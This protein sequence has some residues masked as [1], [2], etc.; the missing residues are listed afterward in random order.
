[1]KYLSVC[2][3]I[4]AA[5]VAWHRLGY[6]PVGFSEIEPFPS[7]VLAHHYPHVPNFGDM[8]KFQEWTLDAGSIDLLVGGT[9]CQSFSVA[10]LRQG[11]KDPR[12]NLMLTYLAIAARLRPQWVVWENVPGV[13]SSNRGRDFGSFL[14]G[15]GQLGYGFAYRVLDAQW[16]RTHGHPCAV[17]QRRRR[18]FVVGCLGNATAAAKVLFERESVQR[19]SAKSG[20]ARKEVAANVEDGTRT[21]RYWGSEPNCADTVTSKWSKGSGGPA[22]SECGLFLTQPIANTLGSRGVRSHTELDGHGAYIPVPIQDG[23]EINKQQNGIGVGQPGDPAYTLDTTGS[24]SVYTK[25]KR[26]QS[27]TDDETWVEGQVNPTLS[28]FD[29]GDVR[30]TTVAIQGSMIGR[31]DHNGPGGSGCSNNGEMFTLTTTDVHAV[32][33]AIPLDLRNS[34]RDPEKHDAQNRQGLGVGSVGDPAPTVD[35]SFVH[36]VAQTVAPTITATNDPSR[37]PQ[38]SEVTQQVAAV[39][40]STMTVRRLTPRECERLQGFPDDYTLIPWRKKAA[41][42]CPDGPRYK[43]LGN[44]MAVNCMAWIGERIAA[45]EAKK[46][47]T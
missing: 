34:Q 10:G 45:V 9:P 24:Q 38:S 26:A 32:A 20:A 1:M 43:A 40:A 6:E 19:H 3:G 4:E 33:Q 8:T 11:L 37:S 17:P 15:L 31:Q 44:S 22:G 35:A 47:T 21:E 18:V 30:T 28:L 12:G 7:A 41:G 36:G 2:S 42:D 5:T 13:L 39:Y 14:G 46:E 29:C 25:A 16:C 23:R 27:D